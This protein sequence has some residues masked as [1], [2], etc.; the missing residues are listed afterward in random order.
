[1][2]TFYEKQK[3]RQ[4][5]LVALLILILFI[6]AYGVLQ[7]V[8]MKIPFGNNPMH[9]WGLYITLALTLGINWLLLASQLETK[10]DDEGIH[11]KYFPLINTWKHFQWS[12]IK[13]IEM[14]EYGFVG[15]GIR[16]HKKY[17]TIY[18]T[19]GN[20]GIFIQLESGK[21]FVIGTNRQKEAEKTIKAF[22]TQN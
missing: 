11:M 13:S 9:D 12:E 19:S 3:M 20:K 8:I 16:W 2:T 15:Y 18:N 22:K 17:N 1:M 7:Q 21:K 4:W 5:W 10:I 14:I 6:P